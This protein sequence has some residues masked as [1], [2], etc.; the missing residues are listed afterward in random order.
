MAVFSAITHVRDGASSE[1]LEIPE[2]IFKPLRYS[3][4]SPTFLEDCSEPLRTKV[5][6]ITLAVLIGRIAARE[7]ESWETIQIPSLTVF[8]RLKITSLA[9]LVAAT[10]AEL[11][12]ISQ[13]KYLR[14]SGSLLRGDTKSSEEPKYELV[15]C[16]ISDGNCLFPAENLAF[17]E[18]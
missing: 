5:E 7:W 3:L 17:Y 2:A 18:H 4:T 8:H 15:Y 9:H 10:R 6:L 12:S 16:K 11:Q 14:S 13:Q 1:S